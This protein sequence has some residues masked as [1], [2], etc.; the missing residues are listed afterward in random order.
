MAIV[1][2]KQQIVLFQWARAH[3]I[4]GCEKLAL[5]LAIWGGDFFC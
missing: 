2:K 5:F 4:R 1:L 3:F